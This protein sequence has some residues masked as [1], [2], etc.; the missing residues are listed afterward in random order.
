MVSRTINICGGNFFVR[1]FHTDGSHF[2]KFLSASAFRR[3]IR[4]R[5]EI[6]LVLPYR[7]TTEF[8]EESMAEVSSIKVQL[9][10]LNMIA[11]ISRDKRSCSALEA[12][13]KKV[14]GL[15]VSIAF[16]GISSLLEA[17]IN[18][19]LALACIDPDL[20]W[21]LVAD[22]YYSSKK[23]VLLPPCSDFPEVSQ[24]LPPPLSSKDYLYVQ[25]GGQSLVFDINI[26]SVEAVFQKLQSAD[27][28]S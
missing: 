10:V 27:I 18:A 6:K 1:R 17:A 24:I 7:S 25:Y 22:V 13:L 23:K 5:D 15:V 28:F 4:S 16:S 11:E 9:A 26:P 2:W 3:N 20:I 21:I 19:L 8:S 14:S 12:V